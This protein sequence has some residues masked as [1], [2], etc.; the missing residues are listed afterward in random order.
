MSILTECLLCSGVLKKVTTS[1]KT[2]WGG[3]HPLTISGIPAEQCEAC[4]EVVF[5]LEAAHLIQS[6][7]RGFADGKNPDKPDLLAL[8]EVAELLR[9]SHQTIYNMVRDGRLQ[10]QKAG[11]EWR[12]RREDLDKILAPQVAMAARANNLTQRDLAAAQKSLA[13]AKKKEHVS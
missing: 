4:N 10:A 1:V 2:N 11:R 3:K 13:K 12:F 6:I 8:P 5:S 7:S 9:V